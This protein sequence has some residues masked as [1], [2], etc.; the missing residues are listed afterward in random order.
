MLVG[1]FLN[2]GCYNYQQLRRISFCNPTDLSYIGIISV[3]RGSVTLTV[4]FGTA[5]ASHVAR[6][7][8]KGVDRSTFVDEL[9]KSGKLMGDTAGRILKNIKNINEWIERHV[10]KQ[11]IWEERLKKSAL[12][13]RRKMKIKLKAKHFKKL[14]NKYLYIKSCKVMDYGCAQI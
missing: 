2:A 8:A 3:E 1:P 10:P 6:R 4:I 5:V 14:V 12:R 13:K 11:K 7:F 9:E